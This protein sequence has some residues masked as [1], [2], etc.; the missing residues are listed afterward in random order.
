MRYEIT[1]SFEIFSKFKA[2]KGFNEKR[3]GETRVRNQR[4]E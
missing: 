2:Y 4:K 3:K 1:I